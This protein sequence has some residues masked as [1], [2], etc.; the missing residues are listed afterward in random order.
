MLDRGSCP[1]MPEH[2]VL[3]QQMLFQPLQNL[4]RPE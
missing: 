2:P 4:F 1:E 3:Q